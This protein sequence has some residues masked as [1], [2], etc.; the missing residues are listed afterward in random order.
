MNSQRGGPDYR[1]LKFICQANESVPNKFYICDYWR[2]SNFNV[3]LI[4]K[5]VFIE[6]I[7]KGLHP[8]STFICFPLNNYA[9]PSGRAV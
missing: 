6:I 4:L 9:C 7:G 2:F 1:L 5:G 3:I 8:L